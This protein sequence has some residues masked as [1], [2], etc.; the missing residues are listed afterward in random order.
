VSQPVLLFRAGGLRYGVGLAD[1]QRLVVEDALVPVPFAHPAMAGLIDAGDDGPVPVFDLKGLVDP[2]E[3]AGHT[4]GATVALFATQ[5][6]PVGLRLD[7]LLGTTSTYAPQPQPPSAT[8]DSDVPAALQRTIVGEARAETGSFSFF[9]PEA[10][11][12]AIGL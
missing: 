11:L 4:K 6:G 5:K 8:M 3:V 2:S 7:E 10:F 12:A 1:V 9:S